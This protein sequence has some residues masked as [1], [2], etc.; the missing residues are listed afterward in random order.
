M[1]SYPLR[2][3]QLNCQFLSQTLSQLSTTFVSKLCMS[4][5]TTS[6]INCFRSLRNLQTSKKTTSWKAQWTPHR[7]LCSP[8]LFSQSFFLTISKKRTS[9][10]WSKA[11]L[12]TSRWSETPCTSTARR[13]RNVISQTHASLTS[14]FSSLRASRVRTTSRA[15]LEILDKIWMTK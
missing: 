2:T 12:L 6:V 3:N 11:P 8:Q 13:P 15:N 7:S 5:P 14:S 4:R 10:K 9:G 1:F